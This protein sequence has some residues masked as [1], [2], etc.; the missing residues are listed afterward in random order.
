MLKAWRAHTHNQKQRFEEK[1]HYH[2]QWADEREGPFSEAFFQEDSIRDVKERICRRVGGLEWTDINFAL[3][4]SRAY[5][6]DKDT[7]ESCK[8]DPLARILITSSRPPRANKLLM[9]SAFSALGGSVVDSRPADGEYQVFVVTLEGRSIAIWVNGKSSVGDLKR[10]VQKMTGVGVDE[11]RLIYGGKQLEGL[12]HKL[13]DFG[14]QK[15]GT[16]NLVG[17]LRG[18]FEQCC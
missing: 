1:I 12:N 17:R 13:T 2:F 6:N 4:G 16:I 3:S 11:Q 7:L 10:E 8:I 15:H 5:L 18:G 14:V 9:N